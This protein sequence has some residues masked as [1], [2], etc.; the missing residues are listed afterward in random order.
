[1][2]VESEIL[3]NI[4]KNGTKQEQRNLLAE[5]CNDYLAEGNV[6]TRKEKGGK[7]VYLGG[8]NL[9]NLKRIN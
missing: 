9:D 6:I 2:K 1:M 7:L 4:M 8:D 3:S 5:M